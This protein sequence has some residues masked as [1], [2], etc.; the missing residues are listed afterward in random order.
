MAILIIVLVF[1]V[2]D[3]YSGVIFETDFSGDVGTVINKS[4][5]YQSTGLPSGWDWAKVSSGTIEIVDVNGESAA[6]FNY[7]KVSDP[8]GSQPTLSLV[9]HLTGDTNTGYS[10]LYIRYSVMLPAT[11]KAGDGIPTRNLAYWK[12]GRLWQN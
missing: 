6:Y 11:F 1:S 4:P 10:E 7:P 8:G 12:F 3:S 5:Y 9:K 2:K